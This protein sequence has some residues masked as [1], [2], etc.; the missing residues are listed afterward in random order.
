MPDHRE[1]YN[2]HAEQYEQLVSQLDYRNNILRALVEI[3]PLEGCR[4]VE[5]GA[6]TGRLTRILAPLVNAIWLF[7]VSHHMLGVAARVLG[8]R[9]ERNWG[10]TVA[11]HRNLPLSDGIADVVIS[12]WSVCYL[13]VWSGEEW[14]R[15]VGKALREMKRVLERKGMIILVEG[16]AT[17]SEQPK[18]PENLI[19]YYECLEEEG[20]SR[21]WIRTD[22][23]FESSEEAKKLL[24]FFFGEKVGEKIIAAMVERDGRVRLPVC[25]AILWKSV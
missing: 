25:T 17:G 14:R 8:A 22:Y 3:H 19:G 2:Q 9:E 23:E 11:D 5:L 15:E 21:K 12:G 20:F 7:D 18:T 13:A 1:I 4:V 10:L 6:G 16:L 24:R